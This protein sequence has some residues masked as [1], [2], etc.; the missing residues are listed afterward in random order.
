MNERSSR[1]LLERL[2]GFATVSRD[3][4]L[5]MI[6]FIRSYLDE[7]GVESELFYNA[8][9]TKAN[10]FA[11]IGPRERGGIVLSGHTDVVPVD[12]QAWTVDPFR[13]TERDGRLYGRGTADMKGYIASVLAAVPGLLERELKLPVH[14]AFSYDEEVG[15]LGVRPMLAELAQRAHKPALCLI[16]EPTELKPVLGHKGK[17][18]MRCQVK[19]APCHS[20]YAPYGVNAIQYA[21]RMIG[22]LEE[23]GEQ[24]AR[25]EHHD[26]RF[27]PPF[28]TV[29]TGVIKGGRALNIVPAECE[30]DFEVRALP[31]FDANRVADELQTYAEA[32]LLP[33]MRAVKADTEIRFEPLSAY[34]GL[35][36]SPD[37]EAARLL[38]LLS[39]S[40]EFGTVA[41]GTEGGLFN[42]AG[43]PAVV[44]GPGS[45]DQGHKPDEFVTVEQLRE[46]DAMLARLA[47]YVSAAS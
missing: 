20:A 27:D 14:L 25:P 10:L 31:G 36:T 11:T 4:N 30:F 47:E 1:A 42:Q 29:Q 32:E 13:L 41:F 22:R 3:S 39:G 45:M 8:E 21:A 12:G 44:C 5:D 2:I 35:A 38:A 19:G 24:L 28:S 37:S 34:P 9:R 40:V 46:C 7:L 6:E 23:I 43:I 16:G 18:A 26:E 17:L 33:K 15:C